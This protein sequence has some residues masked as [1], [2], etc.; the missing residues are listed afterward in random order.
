MQP[1]WSEPVQSVW[2]RPLEH[3]VSS[4]NADATV[5]ARH[6]ARRKYAGPLCLL[7][8]VSV[9]GFLGACGDRAAAIGGG[10]ARTFSTVES[11][12]ASYWDRPIPLQGTA[13]ATYPAVEASLRPADCG[14]C[15]VQQFRDW[16]TTLHANAYSPGLA[17]QLV[18]WESSNYAQVRSCLSCHAPLSEQ[19]ARV[20]DTSGALVRNPYFDAALQESGLVCAACHV[21]GWRRHGPPRRD[22]SLTSSPEAPH[23]GAVRTGYFEDSQF[24]AGCHQFARPAPNGK[25]LQNTHVEWE[26]SRYAREGVTC[27]S[28]HMPDRRHL[29]RGI[30]DS[31][32]VGAGISVAWLPPRSG[33]DVAL[34]VTNT[35]TGHRFPTYVTPK[36]RVRIELLDRDRQPLEGGTAE[37]VIGREVRSGPS[38]WVEEWD[39]RLPPDSSLT[40][41]AESVRGAAY[42]RGTVTVFP[43]GFY[44]AMFAGMLA[45]RLSDTSRALITEAHRRTTA[46]VYSV[47]DSVIAIN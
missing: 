28:C 33:S 12:L 23:G 22:G 15:H 11:F 32:M 37:G 47:L 43:D 20:P 14:T 18:N 8:V 34:L 17:G 39:T 9:S 45:G 16:Q 24:C 30:H 35:G 40:V 38:G 21:R 36:V 31:A 27:Q 25:S 46:S 13:P 29:W 19:S 26:Q 2:G 3:A 10:D 44:N 42:A 5:K 7:L 1:V 4:C 41:R 6:E